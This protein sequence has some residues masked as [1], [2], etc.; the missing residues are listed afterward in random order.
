MTGN[1]CH[2]LHEAFRFKESKWGKLQDEA[3]LA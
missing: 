1:Y 3:K 2:E